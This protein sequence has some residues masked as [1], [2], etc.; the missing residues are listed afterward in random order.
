M[1]AATL[2]Y[3]TCFQ[4]AM[5]AFLTHWALK[6]IGPTPIKKRLFALI[7]CAVILHKFKQTIALLV[8]NFVLGYDKNLDLY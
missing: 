4:L 2:I 6:T 3:R 8:L 5:S 7:F 1:A